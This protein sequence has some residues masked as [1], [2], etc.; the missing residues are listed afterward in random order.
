VPSAR[1]D[2]LHAAPAPGRLV[3]R[4]AGSPKFGTVLSV[5]PIEGGRPLFGATCGT[6]TRAAAGSA[7]SDNSWFSTSP[8]RCNGRSSHFSARSWA[9]GRGP[10]HARASCR[11]SRHPKS[12]TCPSRFRKSALPCTGV[13]RRSARYVSSAVTRSSTCTS[14]RARA[15]FCRGRR[16]DWKGSKPIRIG[17]CGPHSFRGDGVAGTMPECPG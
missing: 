9:R 6:P 14:A 4:P 2:L 1:C 12:C 10:E 13:S 11:E 5:I 8:A 15:G 7:G 3:M 16:P 17:C